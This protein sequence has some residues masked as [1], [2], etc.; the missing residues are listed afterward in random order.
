MLFLKHASEPRR[1]VCAHS[2]ETGIRVV[3][4]GQPGGLGPTT[5]DSLSLLWRWFL[6]YLF[7]L[8]VP[9][10][11]EI[12]FQK[13][14]SK[15]IYM[16]TVKNLNSVKVCELK[17]SFWL[18]T[19]L[20]L[21]ILTCKWYLLSIMWNYMMLHSIIYTR[22]LSK[23]MHILGI[24]KAGKSRIHLFYFLLCWNIYLKNTVL[25]IFKCTILWH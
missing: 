24:W 4:N 22:C 11:I 3:Y 17:K 10:K 2:N 7:L 16:F 20:C 12:S 15:A 13:W 21:G 5:S 6:I 18:L 19:A 23:S 8:F 14:F 1:L 9:S 25:T